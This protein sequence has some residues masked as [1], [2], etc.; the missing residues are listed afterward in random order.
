MNNK[1]K[2][3]KKNVL[4]TILTVLLAGIIFVLAL[5]MGVPLICAAALY[6]G[7]AL[8]TCWNLIVVKIFVGAP[9]LTWL[10]GV[11]LVT[12]LGLIKGVDQNMYVKPENFTVSQKTRTTTLL[13]SPLVS[14][15]ICWVLSHFI[16]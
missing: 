11:G 1:V 4:D 6:N 12:I 16:H 8:A 15:L 5:C 14:V 10:M 3:E 7:W 9:H 2:I 13:I